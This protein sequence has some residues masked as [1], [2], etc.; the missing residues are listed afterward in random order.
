[1]NRDTSVSQKHNL[2]FNYDRSANLS[3]EQ[4]L[5]SPSRPLRLR[6]PLILKSNRYHRLFLQK[7]PSLEFHRAL[8]PVHK[9]ISRYML[10]S[11][12]S[13]SVSIHTHKH[14]LSL[15]TSLS[16]RPWRNGLYV[17]SFFTVHSHDTLG[18]NKVYFIYP[19]LLWLLENEYLEEV[20]RPVFSLLVSQMVRPLTWSL[21]FVIFHFSYTLMFLT[22]TVQ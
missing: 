4:F 11:V 5:S 2:E 18:T 12:P 8:F 13:A 17:I 19:W 10:M 22:W 21:R 14:D 3:E 15:H 6:C 16:F 9:F 1:M 20:V 7:L